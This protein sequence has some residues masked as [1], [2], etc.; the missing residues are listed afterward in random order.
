MWIWTCRA[1][2]SRI[3]R[4]GSRSSTPTTR[5]ARPRWTALCSSQQARSI[6]GGNMTDAVMHGLSPDSVAIHRELV[7]KCAVCGRWFAVYRELV[8]QFYRD[9]HC[10]F[11]RQNAKSLVEASVLVL[12]NK[13]D[14]QGARQPT[15]I[16]KAPCMR[17]HKLGD[18]IATL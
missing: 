4:Y 7:S 14:T 18:K 10:G 6:G 2:R 1:T 13:Q 16:T 8:S 15:A 3:R 9:L 12:A 11:E 17:S 5:P